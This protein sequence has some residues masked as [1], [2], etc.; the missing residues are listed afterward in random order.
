ML[1]HGFRDIE[2]G[3]GNLVKRAVTWVLSPLYN[4]TAAVVQETL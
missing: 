1:T 3:S 2:V 4:V